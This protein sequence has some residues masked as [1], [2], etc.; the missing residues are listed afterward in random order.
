MKRGFRRSDKHHPQ[1]RK[2][3]EPGV[4][5]A[6]RAGL[7]MSASGMLGSENRP[8]R[9]LVDEFGERLDGIHRGC[10]QDP[11]AEIEMWPAGSGRCQEVPGPFPH[12]GQGASRSADPGF[13]EWLR[14]PERCHALL[15]EVRQS[16]PITFPPAARIHGSKSA[17][18][19]RMN[20]WNPRLL[21]RL[22]DLLRRADDKFPHNR[23]GL[24]NRPRNRITGQSGPQT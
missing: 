24:N 4:D 3:A 1:R 17:V 7:E 11:V 20:G 9:V 15:R 6:R 10:L 23:T 12:T 21:Q 14:P 2:R 5:G 13:P 16:T 19:F 18:R 22:E 8:R